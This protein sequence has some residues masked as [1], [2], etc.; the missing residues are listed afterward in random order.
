MR[1]IDLS[2]SFNGKKIFENI[3]IDFMPGRIYSIFG[4][5]GIGKTTLLNI[6]NGNLSYDQ[7]E[8]ELETDREIILLEE[9]SIPFEF[10]TAEEFIKTTFLFKK[11]SIDIKEKNLL[12]KLLEFQPEEKM[13]KDFSKGMK[14]KLCIIIALLSKPDILLLDE[15]F[16]DIDLMSFRNISKIL[17]NKNYN[18]TIVFSTHIAKIAFELAD[19][20]IYLEEVGIKEVENTFENSENLEKYILLEMSEK[21]KN[22]EEEKHV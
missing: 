3:S 1:I 22:I 4:K 6:L 7:G 15:P 11:R 17:R 19:S 21:K 5:N 10:M 9:N 14:S 12:F 8:I 16:S 13:I 18:M 2:K 20:I